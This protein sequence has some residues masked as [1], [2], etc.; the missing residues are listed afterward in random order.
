MRIRLDRNSSVHFEAIGP[1][2]QIYPG[3]SRLGLQLTAKDLRAEPT[4]TRSK[5]VDPKPPAFE[6]ELCE[7]KARLAK[8]VAKFWKL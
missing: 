1:A 6:Y 5:A 2:G 8:R 4:T 7:D 3:Q